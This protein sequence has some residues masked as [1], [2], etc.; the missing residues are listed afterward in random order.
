MADTAT[1]TAI[2]EFLTDL[3][4][5]GTRDMTTRYLHARNYPA[6]AAATTEQL[7][8]ARQKL[9]GEYEALTDA[10]KRGREGAAY[11]LAIRTMTLVERAGQ[12]A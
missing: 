8:S 10:D 9:A 1:R 7:R 3:A 2:D 6:L 5:R 12:D 11:R 4:D